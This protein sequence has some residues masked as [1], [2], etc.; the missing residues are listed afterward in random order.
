MLM[1]LPF[2]LEVVSGP[3]LLPEQPSGPVS[4]PNPVRRRLVRFVVR[5]EES[6]EE[7]FQGAEG[8]EK[9]IDRTCIPP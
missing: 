2:L 1:L 5:D 9:T 6:H 3:G 4:Q 8:L 7:R